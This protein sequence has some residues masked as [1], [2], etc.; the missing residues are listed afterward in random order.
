FKRATIN[1]GLRFD[2]FKNRFPA[3]H[4]GPSVWTPDRDITIPETEHYDMK[5]LTPRV[6]VVYDLTGN[7]RT[8]I[9][10]AWGKYVAG[11]NAVDGNPIFNSAQ[12]VSRSWTPSLPFGDPNYYTPQCD[13]HNPNANGDCGPISNPNFGQVGKPAVTIDPATYT[14]WGNRFWSQEFSASI[15]R[16]IVPRVSVDFGYFRRWYG[17]FQVIDNQ[18]VAPAEFTPYSITVPTDARLPRSGQVLGGFYEVN[19][20]KANIVDNLVTFADNYGSEQ[21]HWNGFDLTVNARPRNGVTL[22]GGLSWGR[23]SSD[24]CQIEAALPETQTQYG[25][26]AYSRDDCHVV[27]PFQTQFKMLGTYLVPK[28][29]VQFGV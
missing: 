11:G 15:Q 4:L 6:G 24:V 21:E 2:Y 18:A 9:K 25:I 27:E 29:D 13:L 5:D 1:G 20:A 8:A 10:A 19:P 28:I 7:G 14:G 22:Q 12:V 3:Q 16:E 23:V 26:F 17:N